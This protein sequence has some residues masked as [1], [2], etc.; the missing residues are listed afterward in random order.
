MNYWILMPIIL[1]SG[2]LEILCQKSI[3]PAYLFPAPSQVVLALLQDP[4]T[5]LAAFAST[6][7]ASLAG[8][9]LSAIVGIC[10]AV[11]LSASTFVRKVFLPYAIFFQT[12]PIIAIAPLLVIWFGYGLPTV[13]AASFIAS[14]FPVIASTVSGFLS[15]DPL[16]LQLFHVHRATRVQEILQLRF[17]F[18]LPRI[19]SGFRIAAGLAVIGAI[20]G[21]FVSGSGLGGIV[22]E[23]RNQ[24]RIDR[25]FACV[26]LASLL[27]I[28]FLGVVNLSSRMLLYRW[29]PEERPEE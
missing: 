26:L 6:S 3:L 18:A 27:G 22:D 25:V 21:E 8:F 20:V 1:A 29:N 4:G 11:V 19:F 7:I 12:V 10:I 14:V 9:L 16:L 17:P 13:I 23:A 5:F 2:I 15:T 24:Q 28:L